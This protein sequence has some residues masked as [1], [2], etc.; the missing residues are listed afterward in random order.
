M[1]GYRFPT[2][3]SGKAAGEGDVSKA[4]IGA[5]SI[6]KNGISSRRNNWCKGPEAQG[7]EKACPRPQSQSAARKTTGLVPRCSHL[8][9]EVTVP[10]GTWVARTRLG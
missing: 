10:L 4:V 2:Q 3:R 5:L 6:S 7:G 1:Q 8:P 9:K